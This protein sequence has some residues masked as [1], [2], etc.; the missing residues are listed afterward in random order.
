MA[1]SAVIL[2]NNEFGT[3]IDWA[4]RGQFYRSGTGQTQS[5]S[6][7]HVSPAVNSDF[8]EGLD[9]NKYKRLES[10]YPWEWREK[11]ISAPRPK[12]ISPVIGPEHLELRR[13]TVASHHI[14]IWSGNQ[15]IGTKDHKPS[16]TVDL[17]SS[18]TIPLQSCVKPPYKLIVGNIGTKP[19]SQTITCENCRLFT[20][21][22]STFNWQHRILLVRAR[23]GM[24][25]PVSMDRPWEALPSIHIL[26][27]VLKGVL[28]RS[29]R[30]IF[31]LIAVIMGLIAVTA[32]AAVA[33]VALHSSVQTVCFVN[34]WQKN[35]TRLW[36]S[37]SGIDQKLAN[38]INDLRQTVIWMGDKLM[39]LE[40]I[41]SYT[42]TGIRQ[43]FVLHPEPIMSLSI[44]GTWLDAI[45]RE[46]MIILL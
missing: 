38:P 30:F 34:N 25:I 2:Q 32:M 45:Y 35:S 7:A 28:N 14:G 21:I 10:P 43:I 5:C 39:S 9:K 6:S 26:T 40:I 37:Q 8:R 1:D 18:L 11:G 15:V 41:F 33:G 4:S 42:V 3:I 31:T 22:D 16:Y 17:N 13:L 19:D 46:G 29:K 27:E 36:N 24:W 44:T 23:E 20:C 12:I